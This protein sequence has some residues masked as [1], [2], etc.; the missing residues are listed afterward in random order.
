MGKN[1]SNALAYIDSLIEYFD[2][3]EST[4]GRKCIEIRTAMNELVAFANNVA[5]PMS[6]PL[7]SVAGSTNR[8]RRRY[9]LGQLRSEA[10]ALIARVGGAA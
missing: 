6:E 10:R 2:G 5:T 7:N 1:R 3:T 9:W 8:D 4:N